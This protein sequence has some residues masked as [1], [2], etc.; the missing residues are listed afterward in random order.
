MSGSRGR[1]NGTILSPGAIYNG[2]VRGSQT[3]GSQGARK[4]RW[5]SKDTRIQ[6]AKPMMN[7]RN[8]G[9]ANQTVTRK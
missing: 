3:I 8:G 2:S 7:S 1:M 9:I 5:N 6:S 4:V